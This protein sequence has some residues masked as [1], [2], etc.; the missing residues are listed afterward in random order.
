MGRWLPRLEVVAGAATDECATTGV[1]P[2][3]GVL[4]GDGAAAGAEEAVAGAEEA[5]VEAAAIGIGTGVL[6]ALRARS[7]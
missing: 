1:G 2:F 4:A 7:R 3:T 5:A 6:A